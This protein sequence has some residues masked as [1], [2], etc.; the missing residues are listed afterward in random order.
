M[1]GVL[2]DDELSLEDALAYTQALVKAE[3]E[4]QQTRS[5][6]DADRGAQVQTA[7][8]WQE[9][10]AA[11]PS[12]EDFIAAPY[13]ASNPYVEALAGMHQAF[14]GIYQKLHES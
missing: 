4:H 12:N 11:G 9:A 6:E 14:H 7:N 1:A 8:L 2:D 5:V 13:R 10:S 3:A